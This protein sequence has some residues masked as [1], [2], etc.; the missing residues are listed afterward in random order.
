M[1]AAKTLDLPWRQRPPS[2]HA[3]RASLSVDRIV[4]A[5]IVLADAEGADAVTMRRVAQAFGKAPM[6]LYT[7]V[8][9]KAELLELMLDQ[10]YVQLPRTAPAGEGWRAGLTAVA[11]D[12]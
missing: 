3:P 2:G 4:D 5:A 12:N 1:D 11:E 7:Y 6:S 9:G 8:P 10:V